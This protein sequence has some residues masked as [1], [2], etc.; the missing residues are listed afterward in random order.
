MPWDEEGVRN[1]IKQEAQLIGG[2]DI[3][4]LDE[5]EVEEENDQARITPNRVTNMVKAFRVEGRNLSEQGVISIQLSELPPIIAP[6]PNKAMGESIASERG[7][8]SA[9]GQED[10]GLQTTLSM[11]RVE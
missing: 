9:K 4:S 10:R 11:N 3:R 5:E 8:D 6:K 1:H 2:A 7:S